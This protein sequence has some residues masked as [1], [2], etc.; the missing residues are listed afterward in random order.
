MGS[1]ISKNKRNSCEK[2][3]RNLKEKVR[4][5]Q[6][7]IKEIMHEREKENGAFER[8][9]M[10]CA[11]K[12]AEWKQER[13]MLKKEVERLKGIVEEK[14]ERI[15]EMKEIESGGE[16]SVK[17]WELV[18]T[19]LLVEQ[20]KEER[21]QREVAVEKWKQLYLAIKIELDEL[22]QRTYLGEGLNWRAEEVDIEMEKLKMEL[23]EK[24][25]II[26]ALQSQLASN[27]QE[28]YKKEREFDILR[29]SLRIIGTKKSS[30]NVR[31]KLLQTLHLR[32]MVESS[33]LTS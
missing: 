26:K 22:I 15:R 16:N 14:E 18:G 4:L 1:S 24:E 19:K 13:K 12:E 5:L 3:V 21:G 28:Q 11:F 25:E 10:V 20:M 30:S 9:M 27:E 23:Q 6:E 32:N 29:Q 33:K 2:D 7:E 31:E 17:E 8:D